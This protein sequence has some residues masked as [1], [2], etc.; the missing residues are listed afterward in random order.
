MNLSYLIQPRAVYFLFGIASLGMLRLSRSPIFDYSAV[1]DRFPTRARDPKRQDPIHL[2]FGCSAISGARVT[3]LVYRNCRA[4]EPSGRRI[5]TEPS[6]NRSNFEL[7]FETLTYAEEES[8]H[9][10]DGM[11]LVYYGR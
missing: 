6:V 3:W 5:L 8:S 2:I 1:V 9:V 11:Q 10:F 7:N 4:A